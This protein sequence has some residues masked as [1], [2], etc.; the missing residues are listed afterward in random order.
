MIGDIHQTTGHPIRLICATLGVPRSSYYHAATPTPSQLSDHVMG[1]RIEAIFRSHR[2]RYGYRRIQSE[3]NDESLTCAPARV[4]R[5][6]QERSLKA[7]QPRTYVPQTS[8]GRADLPSPNLLLGQPLPSQLNQVWAGDITYIP[9]STGWLYL[10]VVM[11]LCSRRIV[12]WALADHLKASLVCDA[13]QQALG[14]RPL[15]KDARPIF[16]S[17]RGSQYG[18]G[19][20]RQLLRAHRIRQSMSA[21]ANP[22]H[23]AWTESFMGT[24]KAEMLQGGTFINAHDARTEIFAYIEAY[25]NTRR[26]HS[27]LAYQTPFRFESNLHHKN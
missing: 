18:S 4:R 6:M 10:A 22:Y 5:L 20:Y 1:D 26:K 24:L 21:R 23:N 8:D 13:L 3:L 27:S 11:D 16:H 15:S 9:T 25:Y 12:G 2:R 19:A 14:S 7:I 17:D